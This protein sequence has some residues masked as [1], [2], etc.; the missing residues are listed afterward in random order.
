VRVVA[1]VV[2]AAT[3]PAPATFQLDVEGSTRFDRASLVKTGGFVSQ[4]KEQSWL[5]KIRV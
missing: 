4:L 5:V 3:P 1:L 2:V